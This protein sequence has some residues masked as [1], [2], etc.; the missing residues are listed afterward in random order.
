MKKIEVNI[1]ALTQSESQPGKYALILQDEKKQRY[2][3]IVIGEFEA[4]SIAMNLEGMK[5][6]RPLTHDLFVHTLRSLGVRL[7]EVQ[8]VDLVEDIFY[9]C[10]VLERAQGEAL[11]ID[12]RTSDALALAV[13]YDCPIYMDDAIFQ[14]SGHLVEQE[15]A[16]MKRSDPYLHCSLPELEKMLMETLANEEYEKA[17]GIRDAIEIKKF[18]TGSNA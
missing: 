8:I 9:A 11:T 14:R 3:P 4:Q 12:S 5:P 6:Q 1:V 7:K 16:A 15:M 10:L 17:S 18:S 13:R 2:L